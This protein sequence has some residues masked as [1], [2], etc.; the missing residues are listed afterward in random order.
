MRGVDAF[1]V[2]LAAA[3]SSGCGSPDCRSGPQTVETGSYVYTPA[4]GTPEAEPQNNA[5]L[6]EFGTPGERTM[7]VDRAAGTVVVEYTFNGKRVVE[8][9]RNATRR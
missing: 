3:L 2:C 1:V 7:T 9:Y 6:G 4:P 5:V 8:R